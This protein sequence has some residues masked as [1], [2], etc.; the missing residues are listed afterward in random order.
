MKICQTRDWETN[1]WKIPAI[2]LFY[3]KVNSAS[4][5]QQKNE[6]SAFIFR[7]TKCKIV[8]FF[9]YDCRLG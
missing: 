2:L 9:V 6:V 4:W 5:K 1:Q 3:K 8:I 7:R